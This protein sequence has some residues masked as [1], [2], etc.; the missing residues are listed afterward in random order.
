MVLK[1][2]SVESNSSVNLIDE[3]GSAPTF[4]DAL[5]SL[6]SPDSCSYVRL[7]SSR[8]LKRTVFT[9]QFRVEVPD[10]VIGKIKDWNIVLRYRYEILHTLLIYRINESGVWKFLINSSS[11]IFSS[12]KTNGWNEVEQGKSDFGD[13]E[14]YVNNKR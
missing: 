10:F 3:V 4:G 11:Q 5:F 1:N 8:G 2:I 14:K 12:M 7:N 9:A 6:C 13:L